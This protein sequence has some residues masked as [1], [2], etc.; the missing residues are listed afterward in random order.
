MEHQQSHRRRPSLC[1]VVALT[2]S[3]FNRRTSLD[4]V[5]A[6]PEIVPISFWTSSNSSYVHHLTETIQY[7][8]RTSCL[9]HCDIMLL[10]RSKWLMVTF[11][12]CESDSPQGQAPDSFLV[13]SSNTFPN[14]LQP[15]KE[16]NV[17]L[18]NFTIS[19]NRLVGLID[20][21]HIQT[22]KLCTPCSEL[23][24]NWKSYFC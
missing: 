13:K 1:C 12:T 15:A 4:G 3:S 2:Y 7:P 11:R 19:R 10:K 6:Y 17:I 21:T 24:K 9:W 18:S 16:E 14:T 5:T 8:R 20:G 23:Y 22:E